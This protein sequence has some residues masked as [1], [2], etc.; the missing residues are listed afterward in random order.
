MVSPRADQRRGLRLA[1]APRRG[2]TFWGWIIPIA[3][4]F[5]PFQLMGDIWRAGLP[6]SKRDRTAWLPA[7]WWTSW[8]LSGTYVGDQR[9]IGPDQPGGS[10]GMNPHVVPMLSDPSF[11]LCALAVSGVLLIPIIRVVSAG[12]V[13]GPPAAT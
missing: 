8:L 4:F 1:A 11:N 6:D 3:N 12:P 2:W 7:L 10:S 5:V 13:G 9:Y